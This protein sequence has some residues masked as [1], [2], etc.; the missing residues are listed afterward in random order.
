[1]THKKTETIKMAPK[2]I[3]APSKP[4]WWFKIIGEVLLCLL[5]LF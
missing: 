4:N 2:K 3:S 5:N 1:M